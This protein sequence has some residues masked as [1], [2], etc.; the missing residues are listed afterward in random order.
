M[1]IIFTLLLCSCGFIVNAQ[2]DIKLFSENNNNVITLY[3]SNNEYCPVSILLDLNLTNMVFTQGKIKTL[4]IPEKTA[5]YKLGE[6]SIA[7]PGEKYKYSYS[8]H[9]NFGDITINNYDTSYEY[10]LPY[11]KGKRFLLFQGYNGSFSHQN[12]NALDFTMPEGTEILAARDGIVIK[13]VDNNSESCPQQECSKYN[14]YVMVYHSDGTFANY[15]HIRFG[16]SKVKP[17]DQIKKGELIALSGNTGWSSGPHLHFSCSLPG[18]TKRETIMTKFKIN[19]GSTAEYL[20]EKGI[21][22]K[23]Y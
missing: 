15:V 17:G 8:S 7:T 6:L 23:D 13:I 3:A 9:Y 2:I 14:N 11:S 5:K 19:N 20:I 12:E 10:D 18:I 16:G 1:K 4:V 21:Y 22:L